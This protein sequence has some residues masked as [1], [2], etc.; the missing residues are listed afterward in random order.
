MSS[1]YDFAVFYLSLLEISTK[2]T[3]A[4]QIGLFKTTQNVLKMFL[5]N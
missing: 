3:L 1:F 5:F 4:A 2:R